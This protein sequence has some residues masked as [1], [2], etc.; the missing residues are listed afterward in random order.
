MW[1]ST[2]PPQR[3]FL[4]ISL[5]FSFVLLFEAGSL[6]F[7]AA[8]GDPELLFF[9][10]L[11]RLVPPRCLHAVPGSLCTQNLYRSLSV[12]LRSTIEPVVVAHISD[13][14]A[15]DVEAGKLW[16]VPA[17]HSSLSK[18]LSQKTEKEVGAGGGPGQRGA[19]ARLRVCALLQN[20]AFG[21]QHPHLTP[22]AACNSSSREGIWSPLLASRALVVW[23]TFPL[24]RTDT[25]N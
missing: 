12:G 2:L 16:P 9:L 5:L 17:S 14:S 15:Q 19:E 3:Q 8:E 11:L 25:E 10:L 24:P 7:R 22:S 20:T 21:S 4:V 23:C 13:S 18:S 1:L 6:V